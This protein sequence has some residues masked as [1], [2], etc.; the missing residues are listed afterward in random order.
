MAVHS[1]ILSIRQNSQKRRSLMSNHAPER[2]FLYSSSA[3]SYKGMGVEYEA[4]DRPDEENE[5]ETPVAYRRETVCE[6]RWSG[7]ADQVY[8]TSCGERH[9]HRYPYCPY[10]GGTIRIAGGHDDKQ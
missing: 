7:P 8:L 6:W 3:H 1:A 10:C 4:W 2:I 5:S 9:A